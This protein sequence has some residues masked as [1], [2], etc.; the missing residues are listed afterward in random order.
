MV[1]ELRD[2]TYYYFMIV[3]KEG[4]NGNVLSPTFFIPPPWWALE[5]PQAVLVPVLADCL[6]ETLLH[7]HSNFLPR[8]N[9]ALPPTQRLQNSPSVE[10]LAALLYI[11]SAWR[12]I[13][14][15]RVERFGRAIKFVLNH[16]VKVHSRISFLPSRPLSALSTCVF[17]WE[18]LLCVQ[19][20]RERNF[21]IPKGFAEN[22]SC[23]S[24]SAEFRQCSLSPASPSRF[25]RF[26]YFST[27]RG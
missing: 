9:A 11:P 12:D 7:V 6:S 21:I 23:A 1:I 17:Y 18:R 19:I 27:D 20:E 10:H 3:L 22:C 15:L 24:V 14:L 25:I 5:H 2:C 26:R 13:L 16:Q 4:N 8:D